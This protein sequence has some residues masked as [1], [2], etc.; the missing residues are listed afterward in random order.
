MPLVGLILTQRTREHSRVA[1]SSPCRPRCIVYVQHSGDG[2]F[3]L[4]ITGRADEEL[5]RATWALQEFTIVF[6]YTSRLIEHGLK[7][8]MRWFRMFVVVGHLGPMP[9]SPCIF[10]VSS[11]R[12][13]PP[14]DYHVF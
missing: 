10:G 6:A 14:T 1:N 5:K 3:S 8:T 2:K 9:P 12:H 7:E 11:Q 4:I 13:A